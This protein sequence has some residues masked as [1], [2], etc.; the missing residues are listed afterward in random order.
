MLATR[1][2]CRAIRFA[3]D[4][5]QADAR[6]GYSDLSAAIDL[7]TAQPD[8]FSTPLGRIYNQRA[9]VVRAMRPDD[10]AASIED[11]SRAVEIE[12][13]NP[14]FVLDRGVARALSGDTAAARVDLRTFESL[15]PNDSIQALSLRDLLAPDSLK[16]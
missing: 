10:W 3:A 16:G 8:A 1:G 4:S 11:L 12:P 7:I 9:F 6:S 14:V 5:V 2:L 15:A 13:R